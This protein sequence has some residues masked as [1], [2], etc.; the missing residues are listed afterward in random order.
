MD[1]FHGYFVTQKPQSQ[2]DVGGNILREIPTQKK[3]RKRNGFEF[4]RFWKINSR[5]SI[6]YVRIRLVSL[7]WLDVWSP[8]LK[9]S[10]NG[11]WTP[12]LFEHFCPRF[13]FP[14]TRCSEGSWS[15]RILLQIW[16]VSWTSSCW[17]TTSL[18]LV[19]TWCTDESSEMHHNA[20]ET[21]YGGR[22]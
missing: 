22:A 19:Q 10:L 17:Y 11:G 7:K 3:P 8:L 15:R 2:T 1:S 4:L 6:V 18:S 12:S 9:Q 16:H 14:N 13:F 21:S 5:R 20:W